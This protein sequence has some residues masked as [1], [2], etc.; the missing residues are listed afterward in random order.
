MLG[1]HLLP[2]RIPCMN[3]PLLG[4]GSWFQTNLISKTDLV[5]VGKSQAGK[6]HKYLI[7][8]G[9]GGLFFAQRRG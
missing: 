3:Q 7:D 1:K 4:Q 2:G 6:R 5:C 9:S 8:R